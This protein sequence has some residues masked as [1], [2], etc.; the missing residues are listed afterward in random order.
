MIWYLLYPLR[1]TTEA[2][3]LSPTH[4]LRTVLT[5]YG[6]YA[7]RH[8]V[9]TLL[10]SVAVAAVLIYP[11]PFLFTNDFING[12]SNLPHHVWT[13]AQPLP[14]SIELEPDV[15]MRSVW[16]HG[17]YMEALNSDLLEAAVDVQDAL[18]GVTEDFDP[19]GVRSSDAIGDGVEADLSPSQR[20]SLHV[21]NGLT[22]QSWFFHS[23]LQ[24]WSSSKDRILRDGDILATVNKQ[25]NLSTSAGMTL[26]HSIVFSGKHFEDRQLRAADALV[27]T[28]LHLRDSPVGRQWERKARLLDAKLRDQWDIYHPDS[29]APASQLYE[30]Q[31]R[32]ISLQDSISLALAYGLTLGYFFVSLSK[33][34]AVKSKVGLMV[35]VVAQVTFSVMSSFTICAVFNMDLSR[36]PRAAYPL[37]I[38]S[39]SLENVFRLINAVIL[40]PAQDS[41]S[42]RIGY[43][44]GETAP[45]AMAST[46]QNIVMLLGL[47]RL[48]SYGVSAF[49]IFAAVAI[50]FDFFYLSTFFLSVLS[51]DVRR[52]ELS[53]ALDKAALQQTHMS[54]STNRER[55]NMVDR[56]LQ[57]KITLST[58]IAGSI[59]TIGFVLI[60]QWHFFDDE[61]MLQTITRLCRGNAHVTKQA[62][63]RKSTLQE[64]HQ[65]RSP[66]SWLRMQDHETAEEV[67]KIIKPT[68]YSYVAQVYEPI[69]LVLKH[70]DR[71]P[72]GRQ[73]ALLPAAYDFVNHELSRAIVIIVVVLAAIRLLTSFLLRDEEEHS[74]LQ[75]EAEAEHDSLLSAKTLAGGHALDIAMLSTSSDGHVVSVGLDRLIRV[76]NVRNNPK[77]YIVVDGRLTKRELFPVLAIAVD[78]SS[79]WL[80]ILSVSQ[81]DFWNLQDRAWGKPVQIDSQCRRVEVFYL[82]SKGSGKS[83]NA[84]IVWRNGALMETT[85]AAEESVA[86]VPI[87]TT[88]LTAAQVYVDCDETTSKTTIVASTKDGQIYQASNNQNGWTVQL[89][90]HIDCNN[91]DGIHQLKVLPTLHA[92][93]VAFSSHVHIV[94]LDHGDLLYTFATESMVPRSLRCIVLGSRST[95]PEES[96]LSSVRLCFTDRSSGD[97]VMQTYTPHDDSETI[98]PFVG[99]SVA[100]MEQD[101]QSKT[102]KFEKRI[103]NP[104]AWEL[105]CDGSAIGVR[106][107]IKGHG[108]RSNSGCDGAKGIR[109]RFPQQSKEPRSR[110]AEYWEMWTESMSHKTD[111]ADARPLV[112]W[113]DG[114]GQLIVPG[115]GPRVTVGLTSVAFGFGN[116][117]KLVTIGGQQRFE[118]SNDGMSRGHRQSAGRRRKSGGLGRTRSGS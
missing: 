75:A 97:C 68:A 95:V 93:V 25:K 2:P 40:T 6:R 64:L 4:P 107:R 91:H 22:N 37:A 28:L 87:S 67:I 45:I 94:C 90:T 85:W 19:V 8:V 115:I 3:V 72:R 70:S 44:W 65:V 100:A 92:L 62:W 16:L 106:S 43:A 79:E 56:V 10:I 83:P 47:S 57:G 26:R 69:V 49:C 23:P 1:G 13:A 12:A 41:T 86:E 110:E 109:H 51:V 48:V 11:I 114:L 27:I 88:H 31:F 99:D 58:R 103:A 82:S 50:V 53:D 15:I 118:A 21:T 71:T 81:V 76:W 39:M 52:L 46:L 74:A 77:S 60:A 117:I 34:R 89:L 17:S 35:T 55:L 42:N 7:A 105:L 59:V 104:G 73:S 112:R 32:P 24:Y 80:A 98:V 108:K 116:V 102:L 5:R 96:A 113:E 61:S 84:I 111:A 18:L 9:T 78:E 30:F 66:T 54:N 36:I 29:Q 20:D 38:L 14:Y 101:G 63:A 33:L